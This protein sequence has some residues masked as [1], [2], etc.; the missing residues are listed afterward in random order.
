MKGGD[1]PISL[2]SLLGR[3]EKYIVG[4][5]A[6]LTETEVYICK[7]SIPHGDRNI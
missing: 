3:R 4:N 5:V 7:L 2:G 1:K 6:Y